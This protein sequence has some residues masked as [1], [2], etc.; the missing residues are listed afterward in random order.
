MEELTLIGRRIPRVDG[1]A[2]ATGKAVFTADMK[3]P[4]MLYGKILRSPEASAMV[5][6]VDPAPAHLAFVDNKDVRSPAG[7][8]QSGG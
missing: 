2:Q 1:A 6:G 7:R 5:L 8:R 3:L 4:G